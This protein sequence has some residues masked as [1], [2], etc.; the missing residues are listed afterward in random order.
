[1]FLTREQKDLKK[2]GKLWTKRD[3][4]R[5][6]NVLRSYA[7]FDFR[8]YFKTNLQK[9][10]YNMATS[11]IEIDDEGDPNI[12]ISTESHSIHIISNIDIR[13]DDHEKIVAKRVPNFELMFIE[14]K[15]LK[16]HYEMS[17]K[18]YHENNL[19]ILC[20]IYDIACV[21]SGADLDWVLINNISWIILHHW[22]TYRPSKTKEDKIINS[23]SPPIGKIS[24][25]AYQIYSVI[26]SDCRQ[27]NLKNLPFDF[28][29]V[30]DRMYYH[31]MVQ[32]DDDLKFISVGKND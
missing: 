14:S 25:I 32:K 11:V 13:E 22:I 1:M 26:H 27:N 19:Q 9:F 31:L 23:Q 28:T 4:E 8:G 29:N 24:G 17:I 2:E 20:T 3:I 10:T 30:I 7:D 15:V 6:I 18:L 16:N 12:L 21:P 5:I